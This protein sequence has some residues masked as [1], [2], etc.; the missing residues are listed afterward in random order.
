MSSNKKVSTLWLRYTKM[1]RNALAMCAVAGFAVVA[2]FSLPAAGV[3]L[4]LD[5]VLLISMGVVASKLLRTQM[6]A[7]DRQATDPI[8]AASCPEQPEQIG[9][10]QPLGRMQAT[11]PQQQEMLSAADNTGPIT[12]SQQ[13]LKRLHE[14]LLQAQ[15][16]NGEQPLDINSLQE[17]VTRTTKQIFAQHACQAVAFEVVRH[18]GKVTLQP[19]IVR[20]P[21][22]DQAPENRA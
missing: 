21:Q 18:E 7:N 10:V 11:A 19:R 4:L 14:Q 9:A 6:R 17:I 16:A 1:Y 20:E 12:I 13:E 15:K 5:I 22:S 2:P 8:D 3:R